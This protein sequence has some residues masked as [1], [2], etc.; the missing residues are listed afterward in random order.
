MTGS[1]QGKHGKYYVVVRIATT[2]GETKQKWIPTNIPTEGNNKRKAQKAMYE[3]LEELSKNETLDP[4]DL[5]FT[6]WIDIWLAQKKNEIRQNTY[7]SY[8]LFAKV[9]IK[10]Y[11][12]ELG[13]SLKD[14]KPQQIHS[15]YNMLAKTQNANTVKKHHVIIHGAL[16]DALRKNMIL[17]DPSERV[18][19]PK[20]KARFVGKAYTA[21]QANR[22]L[23]V[24]SGT[25]IEP[26]I[27]LG[28]YYGLRR[29]EV[30]GLRWKDI[31]FENNTISIKNTV[32][33]MITL[34]EQETTKSAA[35]RRTMYI[36]PVTKQ[37]FQNL[38]ERQEENE[39]LFGK[40]YFEGDHVCI[41]NDGRPLAPDYVSHSFKKLLA[42]N[43]LP[44]LR[45][46]ELRHTAGS[47]LLANGLSIKQIQEY[48][49][50]ERV[51]TTLDIYGHLTTE[52]KQEAANTLNSMLSLN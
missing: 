25:T 48:L 21:E 15:Y 28:L 30:L 44:P 41:W 5:L 38:K 24:I 26:A 47:L 34:S 14:I 39:K 3:I 19:L 42:K 46:H 11:F 43:N 32:V 40:E 4:F 36:I 49:G 22:L 2:D 52:G 16:E 31:D 35:S 17:F 6:D 10:P 27:I 45:F 51:S 7:E 33:K 20:P 8:E 13:V 37:Y 29:S 23:S 1:L 9:H 50:H 12:K 18:S